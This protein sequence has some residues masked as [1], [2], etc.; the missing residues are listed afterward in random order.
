MRIVVNGN[1]TETSAKTVRDLLV[2]LGFRDKPVIVEQ[3][4]QALLKQELA[5]AAVAENDRI[6]VITLAAG[7]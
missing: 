2:E 7:G 4:K 5:E 1:E 6:E 3:N